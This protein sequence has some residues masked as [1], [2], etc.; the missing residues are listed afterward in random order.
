M[1]P[2]L[3]AAGDA[4]HQGTPPSDPGPPTRVVPGVGAG[5]GGATI[6]TVTT[7]TLPVPAR[8]PLVRPRSGRLLA[9]VA[10][11]TA[12]HLRADPLVVRV[13][14]VVL[15]ATGIGVVAYALLWFFMPVADADAA[16]VVDEATLEPSRRQTLG[17]GLLGLGALVLVTQL[18][19]WG[20][21]S[22]VLVKAPPELKRAVD[23]WG[24]PGD[25]IALMRRVKERFDPDRRLSPGR[26]VGGI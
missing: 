10:A 14:F 5:R 25:T 2:T 24:P 22:L 26:F 16:P 20:G 13:A 17:L 7:T 9:G 1:A 19:S 21:G 3:L 11:G 15:A 12:V 8:P 23:V 4:V 18:G 6:S